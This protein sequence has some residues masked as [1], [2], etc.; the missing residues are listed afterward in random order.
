MACYGLA[1]SG[2]FTNSLL[3]MDWNSYL[4]SEGANI[5]YPNGTVPDSAFTRTPP[6]PLPT[7]VLQPS[8]GKYIGFMATIY[9]VGE[10][11]TA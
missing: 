7:N 1:F 10:T 11:S 8:I 9:F 5:A 6:L 3:G 2:G 4:Q